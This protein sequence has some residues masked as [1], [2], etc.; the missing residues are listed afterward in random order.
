M[1][2]TENR[3]TAIGYS[4]PSEPSKFRVFVWRR[5]RAIGAENIK[6]GLAV[7]PESANGRSLL[8]DLAAKVK[9]MGG[10]ASIYTLI[11]SDKD[12]ESAV[13]SQFVRRTISVL[14]HLGE[15][16]SDITK[17]PGTKRKLMSQLKKAVSDYEQLSAPSDSSLRSELEGMLSSMLSTMRDIPIAFEE[18]VKR[19]LK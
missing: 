9:Q 7:L 3:Y 8:K 6:P 4:V 11:F 12:E 10:E 1:T 5:L 18:E 17:T 15:Q 13:M 2:Y 14:E 19:L 16:F